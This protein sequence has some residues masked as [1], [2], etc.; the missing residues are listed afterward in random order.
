MPK[1]TRWFIKAGIIYF[2]IGVILALVSELST[3]NAGASPVAR[4]L[5]FSDKA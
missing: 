5:S 2:V 3:I 1:V 4:L